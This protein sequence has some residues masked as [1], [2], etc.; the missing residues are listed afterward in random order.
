MLG[1]DPASTA[2][3]TITRDGCLH[4]SGL[5]WSALQRLGKVVGEKAIFAILATCRRSSIA[6]QR[7]GSCR[8]RQKTKAVKLDVAKYG[9]GDKEPLLRWFV[10]IDAAI[11]SGQ[12]H[13][14]E[15]QVDFAMSKLAG[16]AK[17]WAFGRRMADHHCFR[18]L[19]EFK[20]DIRAA[21]EPPKSEF[22][23]RTEFLEIRQDRRDLHTY[24]QHARYL[25]SS[26]VSEPIDMATQVAT[27]MKGL[28]DGPV[29]TYL[30][31]EYPETLEQAITLA[32][33]EDF[34][35]KQARL[36]A[37]PYRAAQFRHAKPSPRDDGAEPMDLSLVQT[38]T[39]RK[40]TVDKR[41]LRG[42]ARSPRPRHTSDD[43]FASNARRIKKRQ[44]PVDAG[45]S[46]GEYASGAIV[47]HEMQAPSVSDARCWTTTTADE[48]RDRLI[49][50]EITVEGFTTPLRGLLDTG[51]SSNFVRSHVVRELA[52]VSSEESHSSDPKI[53]V[54][55]A[56]G[57]TVTT[58]KH[59]TR[60]RVTHDGRQTEG[61]FIWLDLDD[62]FD[63]ILGMPRLK[64]Y[65]PIIDWDRQ[66]IRY[67]ATKRNKANRP[68]A[69][70][71]LAVSEL[72][73]RVCD[74]P[75]STM[76]EG[77]A[78]RKSQ[79]QTS[80][81][82]R[83]VQKSDDEGEVPP[84]ETCDEGSSC[85]VISVMVTDEDGSHIH[86]M[87]LEDPP[88]DASEVVT[89]PIMSQKRFMKELRRGTL[90][91]ICYIAPREASDTE[92]A[93][94]R[95][96]LD[97]CFLVSSSVM[98]TGVLDE[99]TKKERFRAQGWESLKNSPFYG[100]LK[101]YEDVFPEDVPC[102]LPTDEGVRREVNLKV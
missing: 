47:V 39:V 99:P 71:A 24:I 13:D 74:G 25:V 69:R 6:S 50:F 46:T 28:T 22:R 35:A 42:A 70:N 78:T 11:R 18:T 3:P 90:E 82:H 36:R 75:L 38:S 17:S 65:Q 68:S 37:F 21:F 79:G 12:I 30:F 54:R 84:M 92:S 44:P 51:A 63:V 62:K 48:S 57:A 97:E 14:P 7:L 80:E 43:F 41:K 34:G 31:R 76:F 89:L 95:H 45:R 59:V 40:K 16:R 32:L 55:L 86:E 101:E 52:K 19:A 1:V 87:A 56:T 10:E 72:D 23:T 8:R 4:L 93:V 26:I 81:V 83:S 85:E 58:E 9:G 66:S 100:L 33:Q 15:Q 64:K 67:P 88:K 29:K 5:E 27:F 60:L 96:P 20:S 102:H 73:A 94:Q 2:S 53:T 98:D 77:E 49:Q 91:Q 61:D